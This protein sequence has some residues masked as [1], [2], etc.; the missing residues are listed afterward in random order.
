MLKNNQI[1]EVRG[2]VMASLRTD[3]IDSLWIS[4][5]YR[6][7]NIQHYGDCGYYEII[8][9]EYDHIKKELGKILYQ[10]SLGNC[11]VDAR[12]GHERIVNV[13]RYLAYRKRRENKR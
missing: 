3:M 5:A 9:W 4:T 1:R 11:T 12:K 13:F 2:G 7:T 6:T 8:V 10:N